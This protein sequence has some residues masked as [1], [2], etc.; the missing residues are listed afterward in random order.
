MFSFQIKK[1]DGLARSGVISTP[2][3][4]IETPAFVPV[5]TQASVKAVSPLDLKE[6][7]VSVV[8][9]NTYHLHLRPGEEIIEKAGGLH[10]FMGWDGPVMTDSGGFQVFSLGF[11]MEQGV[12]KIANIFPEETEG[13]LEKQ[14]EWGRQAKLARVDNEGVEFTSHLDGSLLRLTP[15]ISIEIQ[16]KLGADIILAFDE[17]TSPLHDYEYTKKALGRT[18]NWAVRSLEAMGISSSSAARSSSLDCME[19]S[20][21][22]SNNKTRQAIYGIVQGGHFRDLREESV[23]YICSLP[24]DGV[25]I[26][27]DLGRS[28]KEMHQ[29]LEWVAPF[30]PESMPRHLLGIGEV[31]DIFEGVE[32]GMDTFDCVMA[33]RLARCGQV[34]VCKNFRPLEVRNKF[35]V[36]LTKA[37]FQED[38][39]SIEEDCD[40]YTCGNFSRAY[41]SH[42]FR[43]RELLAFRLLTIHN[44][45]FMVRLMKRIRESIA[46]GTFKELK[47]EWLGGT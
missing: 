26:G 4:E 31:E 39:S 6:A 1:S 24:F 45:R 30:L 3:G 10:R 11:G 16:K 7:G 28:K 12:G 17:C 38:L 9:A 35:R 42:L 19:F 25:A 13:F 40:C 47:S 34:L 43:A 21:N 15:E 32:R 18:H 36:D 2:N 8:I 41:L 22:G 27:G 14:K 20:P 33:T 44:L 37:V 29:I 46:G 23:R 5:A